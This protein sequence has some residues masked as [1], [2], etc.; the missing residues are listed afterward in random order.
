MSVYTPHLAPVV[1]LALLGTVALL[2]LC[3]LA[4]FIGAIRK[5]RSV[6]LGAAGAGAIILV[7]YASILFG[8]SLVSRDV[9]ISRGAWKY[10]CELDC[11]IAYTIGGVQLANSVGSEMQ[12]VSAN[13]RF[14]IVQVKT[15]F[16]P[17][18]ISPY[19]GNG[20][21]TPN[22]R[23]ITL[24]D[25][26][27]RRF[28]P[29]SKSEPVLTAAGLHSTPLRDALRPGDSYVSYIVFEIPN[30]AKG[31]RLLLTSSDEEGLLIWGDENS[32]WHGKSYF[33]LPQT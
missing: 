17:M 9:E 1:V 3:V 13:G 23:L 28:A 12:S 16:D 14:A 30:D 20:P 21:L 18:T 31:L 27:G 6:V 32:P 22:G 2:A 33:I 8:L 11:H 25:D 26:H 10:F 15:W 4:A 24:L 7:G 29:S 5:S 19:R